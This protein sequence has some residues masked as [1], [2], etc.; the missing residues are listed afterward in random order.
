[1]GPRASARAP[2]LRKV[3]LVEAGSP[4]RSDVL[5]HAA[6]QLADSV[7]VS[8]P[9]ATGSTA[10]RLRAMAHAYGIS[11]RVRVGDAASA[12]TADITLW[13][14]KEPA[15]PVR[16]APD[17]GWFVDSPDHPKGLRIGTLAEL[18]DALRWRVDPPAPHGAPDEVLAGERIAVVTNH[19]THYRVALWNAVA[20][21][22]EAVGGRF[23][24]LFSKGRAAAGRPWLRHAEM[25]F[26]HAFLGGP[27]RNPVVRSGWALDRALRAFEPTLLL[28]GGFSPA[29]TGVA[30]RYARRRR[31]PFGVWSGDTYRQGTTHSRVRRLERTWILRRASFGLAYGWL[32]AEYLRSLA[33]GLPVVLGRNTTPH[34]TKTAASP[35]RATI[36]VL[37][38]GQAIPRKGLDLAIDAFGLVADL[39]CRLT[40]A[41]G[42]SELDRLR[43]RAK[44]SD[45]IRFLGPV[46]SD[47]ILERY[48]D[49]DLFLFP[50]RSDV[51][52]LVLVE[53]MGSGLA[54]ITSSAPGAV[55]DL[56]VS[57]RNSLILD[58]HD[59]HAWAEAI[60]RLIE[61][62]GLRSQL[63]DRARDTILSRWTIEHSADAW[64]AA[65]RLGL[66]QA[67]R[68][69]P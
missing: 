17:L 53:A 54:T 18:I 27:Q 12:S 44:G 68:F 35:E 8:I 65:F 64:I 4:D 15:S 3:A 32:A 9:A 40:I 34:L 39:P 6:A 47:R 23:H 48:R 69:K 67:G 22:V 46:E 16:D 62:R 43:V 60:R 37:A 5:I 28:S 13:S 45:R 49:A 58:N 52:G 50:S 56:C 51:F 55:D 41:G 1:M 38:V 14:G 59:P 11:S 30:V 24:V 29:D 25:G 20:Q 21:R 2:A 19:P 10:D 63:G 33:A 31:V 57:G 36:E 26:E 42:G 7:E 61:D 66:I